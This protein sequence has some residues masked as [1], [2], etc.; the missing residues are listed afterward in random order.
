MIP[1]MTKRQRYFLAVWL[2]TAL[3]LFAAQAL[4]YTGE[5]SAAIGLT[6]LSVCGTM[7]FMFCAVN[8]FG[9][10]RSSDVVPTAFAIAV[11]PFVVGLLLD[12]IGDEPNV[13]GAAFLGILFNGLFSELTAIG[14][15]ISLA[16]RTL[17][18]RWKQNRSRE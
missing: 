11:L 3:L 2:G 12:R 14:L 13:H 7:G 5:L 6:A 4:E 8:A 9:E 1:G 16:V 18:G 17:A 10:S 15:L